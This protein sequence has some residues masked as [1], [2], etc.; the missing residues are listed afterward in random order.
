MT[1]FSERE[2]GELPRD[3]EDIGDDVWGG[4]RALIRAC[5]EDGSFGAKYPQNCPDGR[6]PIGTD[7][8][9]FRDA[10]RARVLGLAT[11]PWADSA[12]APSTLAILILIEFCWKNVSKPIKINYHQHWKHYDLG[13][14]EDAG[15]EQ[16]RTDIEDIFRLNGLAYQLTEEG[17]IERLLDP[18]LRETLA[19][20]EYNTGDSE[21]DDLLNKSKLKFLDPN[22]ET[23][24]EALESLW[25]A[26]E[27]FKSLEGQG[28]VRAGAR[29]LLDAA[30]GPDAPK[31]R[32]ALE[33]EAS[34][35][36]DIGNKHGIRH[37]NMD[38]ERLVKDEHVDY[39]F[40]RMFS[41][42]HMIL[43]LR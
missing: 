19:N 35:L 4:I 11:W 40:H 15:R 13:F 7:A 3:N 31:F 38:Q 26:W 14:D 33:R 23:R 10:M 6:I 42:I 41:L 8:T 9:A 2:Y 17:R 5:V 1:Y 36:R 20:Q 22:A 43:R 28:D 32:E 27:K 37:R 21:I 30:A 39:L 16:F 29:I 25:D 34:E 24:R 18:V 12:E